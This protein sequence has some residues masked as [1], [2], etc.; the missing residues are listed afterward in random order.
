MI[1]DMEDKIVDR[2]LK[3]VA[4][5]QKFEAIPDEL[6]ELIGMDADELDIETMDYV[7]AASAGPRPDFN[8]FKQYIDKQK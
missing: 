4:E 8:K 6:T 7:V 3:D 2:R 5:L 1:I